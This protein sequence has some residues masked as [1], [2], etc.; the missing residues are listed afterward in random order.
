MATVIAISD[1]FIDKAYVDQLLEVL[2]MAKVLEEFEK[3]ARLMEEQAR[4]SQSQ[5]SIKDYL[6]VHFGMESADLQK[7]VEMINDLEQLHRLLRSLYRADDQQIMEDL[8][9]AAILRQENPK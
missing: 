7:R 4:V 9:E 8:I 6:D 5:N 1:K 2:S 3:R